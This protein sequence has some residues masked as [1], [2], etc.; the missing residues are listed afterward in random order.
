[1]NAKLKKIIKILFYPAVLLRRKYIRNRNRKWAVNDPKKLANYYYK[2]MSGHDINWENPQ[3]ISEK[4]NW[5]KFYSDTS[6]WTE[7]ADK[8][9]VRAYVESKGL[10]DIL[11]KLYGVWER[12]EDIDFTSLPDSFVLKTNHA[13]GTVLLV[14]DKN[15]L[16]FQE[17]LETLRSWMKMRIGIETVEPH[18]LSIKPMII[19]EEYLNKGS[20]L[21]DYKLFTFR[22]KTELVMVCSNRKIGVSSNISLYT[23]DWVFCPER[24]GKCH[25]NDK[26]PYQ[27]CPSA[28][29][30][31]KECAY[32]LA[33]DF[34][35]VRMDF[36][37][38][39]GKVY[40]GEMTFTPKGGYC[41]TL[42]MEEQLRLGN[43]IDLSGM[44]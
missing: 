6:K 43:M 15:K 8:Y 34:P 25:A 24:L 20:Q 16:N 18:Y 10:K 38:V 40:F 36:Y 30:K 41:S 11:V 37:E 3:D 29:N 13:C 32:I 17:T 33:E 21:I 9:K 27:S 4:I 28:F 44:K 31:M 5:M 1:M 39:N 23:K 7:L 26:V 42:T 14:E 2:S 35:F 22:G 19:A 12:P